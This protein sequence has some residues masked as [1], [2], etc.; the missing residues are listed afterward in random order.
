MT[1]KVI[2]LEKVR[3]GIFVT[4]IPWGI[5]DKRANVGKNRH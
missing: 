4:H 3:K 2:E 1:S 5:T